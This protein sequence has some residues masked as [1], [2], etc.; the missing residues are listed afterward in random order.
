MIKVNTQH[1]VPF[2]KKRLNLDNDIE[3]I[4]K[5]IHDKSGKGN[6]FL[7]WLDQPINI[8]QKEYEQI[9]ASAKKIRKQSDILVVIGI[10]GSYLGAKAALEMLTDPFHKDIEIIFAGYQIS[11]TYMKSLMDYLKG[12]RFSINVISKSG[13]TTE[14]AIAFRI[15][16]DL[17]YKEFTDADERIYVT[18]DR[19][20]GALK[21]L[22]DEKGYPTFTVPDDIG[23]RFSVFSAVGLLP[24]AAAGIDVSSILE[25]AKKAYHDCLQIDN[26]AYKYATLRYELYRSGKSVEMLVNYEPQLVYLSEFWKQ[27]FGESEGKEHKSL[28]V[29]SATFSTDLHSLGQMIQDGPRVM[30]ETV[31][32]VNKTKQDQLIPHDELD[33]DGL[34]YLSG[35]SMQ[36]VNEKAFLGTLLAHVDGGVPNIIIEMDTID[37]YHFGYL[38]YFF[39]KACA[40]S[41]Y[42]LDVNPFDQPGVE[43]YKRN[44]FALLGK[45]GFED[46]KEELENKLK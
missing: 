11:A 35:K 3:R 31:I 5:M 7:G 16:K 41:A 21:R 18:T 23:G 27:L 22:A 12:K 40:M 44:M 6:D 20:R 39:F 25:G 15:L 32:K 4:H 34:N 42:L 1:A 14:P 36:F 24:I 8:D 38:V 13:T 2:L 28:F 26:E 29:S 30:F 10:G 17:L 9:L 37:S 19:K 33:L 43:S 46:L 45:P